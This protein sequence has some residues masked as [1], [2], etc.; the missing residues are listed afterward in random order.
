M[1]MDV[2]DND[3]R[4]KVAALV[5]L[6]LF[7]AVYYGKMLTQR[8]KGIVTSQIGRRKEKG[9]HAVETTMAVA[10]VSV[11]VSQLVS[12]AIGWHMLLPNAVRWAGCGIGLLGD[13]VFLV[14]VLCMAD[15]WRAGIPDKDRTRL[16][17]SGIY[18]VSRNPAFLGFDLMYVGVLML[19]FNPATAVFSVFAMV[20]LHLQILQEERFLP[21]VFGDEYL[22]YRRTVCRYLGRRR[23]R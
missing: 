2:S 10:T 19:F 15:S 4:F 18:K 8:R 17:T 13:V 6:A 22:N 20:M 11:V 9:L 1:N 12:I 3:M 23:C 21:T 5:V 14:S 16:V 7:Y